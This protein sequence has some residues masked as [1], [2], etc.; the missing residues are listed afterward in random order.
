[1]SKCVIGGQKY[2]CAPNVTSWST[3]NGSKGS[4]PIR[5]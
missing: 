4:G 3:K 1:M 5:L 2:S